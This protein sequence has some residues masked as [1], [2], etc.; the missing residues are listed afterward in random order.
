[1][2][3]IFKKF[4]VDQK[5]LKIS[6]YIFGIIA[7]SII[8]NKLL[9]KF[10]LISFEIK[11]FFNVTK[12]ILLPFIYG[13]CIAYIA[14]PAVN[15]FEK[16]IFEK[17]KNLKST[18]RRTFSILTTYLIA[19][20]FIVWV[21]N[22][23]I[24]EIMI[25]IR[26]FATSLPKNLE[27]L[28]EQAY[29]IMD[30]LKFI[31]RE[32]LNELIEQI[33]K[34]ILDYINNIP[35]ISSK[36]FDGTFVTFIS[37]VTSTVNFASILLKAVIGIFV[38]FY[39]LS[40][41]EA[42]LE[43]TKKIII[44]VFGVNKSSKIFRNT[45]KVHNNFKNF[46][47]GKALDSIIIGVL[48]F[49]GTSLMNIPYAVII[50]VIIGVTNMIP[51]F[52]PFIGAIPSIFIVLLINPSKAI[53]TLLFVFILQQFDGIYL[54]PK[55]LG[56]SV[57]MSPIWIILSIIIGGAIMGPLG[58]FIGVPIFASLKMFLSDAIDKKYEKVISETDNK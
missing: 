40:D 47:V 21:L 26:N 56:N 53:L 43:G 48:C 33:S 52:G 37:V 9:D 36:V 14:C 5:Y 19:I 25:N 1:M 22:Y 4:K 38:S 27:N 46:I 51:Y 55:I 24:P 34:P 16:K 35:S 15:F 39:M 58:M 42:F 8:L 32:D 57:G 29:I 41:K 49:I 7:I 50:S 18:S 31:G 11:S 30:S 44:A 13:F 54:G 12:N 10:G 20:G 28:E 45:L 2:I 23:F 6:I 3:N 17:I